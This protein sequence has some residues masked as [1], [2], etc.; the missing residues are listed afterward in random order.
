[1]NWHEN[2][3]VHILGCRKKSNQSRKARLDDLNFG[4]NIN[5]IAGLK[6]LLFAGSRE[7]NI[8]ST[9]ARN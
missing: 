2:A 7:Q 5:P 1:M 3:V 4:R 6:S 8:F 9:L